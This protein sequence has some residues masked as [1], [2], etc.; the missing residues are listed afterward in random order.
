MNRQCSVCGKSYVPKR[1][2][3]IKMCNDCKLEMFFNLAVGYH[4]DNEKKQHPELFA[5]DKPLESETIE[6]LFKEENNE[7]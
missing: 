7:S 5:D 2:D 6:K 3:F 1:F 4:I